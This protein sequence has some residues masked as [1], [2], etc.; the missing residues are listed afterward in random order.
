MEAA[1]RSLTTESYRSAANTV[2][3]S[4][5]LGFGG[6]KASSGTIIAVAV[7]T[8]IIATLL[9]IFVVKRKKSFNNRF[10]NWLKEYLNFRS[11]VISSIIKYLYLFLAVFLT[12]I[13][14]VVMFGDKNGVSMETLIAGLAILVLGN[15]FLRIMLELTM[16]IIMIWENSSSIRTAIVEKNEKEESAPSEPVAPAA[17]PQEEVLQAPNNFPPQI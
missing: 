2:S 14:F 3:D 16:S 15:V 17:K 11:I 7:I 9:F 1:T 6:I 13:S 12:I 4:I 10:A 8:F 5:S